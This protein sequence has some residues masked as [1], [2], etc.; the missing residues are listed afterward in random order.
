[1]KKINVGKV[2]YTC[3]IILITGL[4]T[5]WSVFFINNYYQEKSLKNGSTAALDNL[6][7]SNGN[8]QVVQN[9]VERQVV[10]QEEARIE[11]INKVSPA[12]VGVVNFANNATQGEGSGII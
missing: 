1:M 4:I 7:G 10:T 6:T 9:V 2:S 3:A 12:I 5:A 11:A 8:S